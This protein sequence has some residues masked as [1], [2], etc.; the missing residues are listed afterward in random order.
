MVVGLTVV[1]IGTSSPELVVSVISAVEKSSDIALGNIIGSNI[2]N[3]GLILGVCSLIYHLNCHSAILK[4]ELPIMV[5]ASGLLCFFGSDL[6]IGR[7]EGV[8]L[9]AGMVSFMSYV[10]YKGLREK[11]DIGL[12]LDGGSDGAAGSSGRL[13]DIG[14][15]VMGFGGLVAGSYMMVKS[16]VIIARA[17]GVSEFVIGLIMVA[18]G[19][20]LPELAT[21]V[22]AAIRKETDILVGNVIGSNISNVLWVIGVVAIIN[23]LHVDRSVLRFELP[24][25]M[26][27]SIALFA[28]LRVGV[29]LQRVC[30]VAMLIGYAFVVTISFT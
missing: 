21:S 16:S 22:A 13:R 28:F 7:T 9:L 23:P 5:C 19:T 15:T 10:V 18:I 8:I 2:C 12:E 1:A 30:G 27:F 14:Y 26:A 6:L 11:G 17:M 20:S 4:K 29:T 3:I 24:V 25:M